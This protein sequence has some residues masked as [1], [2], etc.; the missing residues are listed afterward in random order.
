MFLNAG[1]V[2]IAYIHLF[3]HVLQASK[4]KEI[5]KLIML[6]SLSSDNKSH[7]NCFCSTVDGSGNVLM[8]CYSSPV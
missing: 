5:V 2:F 1:I 8:Y 4:L 3:F 6:T 7:Q